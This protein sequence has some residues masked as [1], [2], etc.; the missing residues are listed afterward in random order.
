MKAAYT[1]YDLKFTFTARTSRS[2]MTEKETYLI[3]LV[4]DDEDPCN[5]MSPSSVGECS[6][7]RGLSA[8]DLPDYELH[9]ANLCSA[10]NRGED[11]DI[12]KYSSIRFGLESALIAADNGFGQLLFRTA[13]TNGQIGLPINGLVWMDSIETMA[14]SA[15]QK[16]DVGFTTV[17]LKIRAHDFEKELELIDRL[18]MEFGP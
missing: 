14:I 18:R 12:S 17:K 3:R 10:V 16:I 15:R 1:R 2:A 11:Y 9:I 8:D 13:F 6:V 4:P 7:F 5:P